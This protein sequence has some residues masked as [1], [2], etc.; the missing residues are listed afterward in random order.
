MVRNREVKDVKK[1][2]IAVLLLL[3]VLILGGI[4]PLLSVATSVFETL[5]NLYE[6]EISTVNDGD[7][8]GG[9]QPDGGGGG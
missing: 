7:G 9:G 2:K 3:A 1:R 5:E 4:S 6:D 8:G